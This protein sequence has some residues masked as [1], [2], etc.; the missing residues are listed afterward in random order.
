M[1][2][3]HVHVSETAKCELGG[4]YDKIIY[5]NSGGILVNVV[6]FQHHEEIF[7]GNIAE[8]KNG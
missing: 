2:R 1:S 8:F 5:H 7:H 4:T 6:I 3:K